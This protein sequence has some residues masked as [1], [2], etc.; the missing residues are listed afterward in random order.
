MT[1]WRENINEPAEKLAKILKD[2]AMRT[3]HRPT[4]MNNMRSIDQRRFIDCPWITDDD[5]NFARVSSPY[6]SIVHEHALILLSLKLL[7]IVS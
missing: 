6:D 7:V 2:E 1:K 3:G 4:I 5:V